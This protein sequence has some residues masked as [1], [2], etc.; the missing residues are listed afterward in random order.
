[1]PTYEYQCE[2]CGDY[3]TQQLPIAKMKEPE[4]DACKKC[5]CE[6]VRKKILS[7]VIFNADS[8]KPNQKYKELVREWKKTIPHNTLPDY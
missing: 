3:F 7:G 8:V 1:M 4:K 6:S 5:G 2:S